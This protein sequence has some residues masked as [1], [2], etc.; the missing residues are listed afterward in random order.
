MALNELHNRCTITINENR[1]AQY[2]IHKLETT[3]NF[4]VGKCIIASP[5]L[6]ETLVKQLLLSMPITIT[7]NVLHLD[8]SVISKD[9]LFLIN[10]IASLSNLTHLSVV[11]GVNQNARKSPEHLNSWITPFS[12]GPTSSSSSSQKNDIND[13]NIVNECSSTSI[14]NYT[15]KRFFVHKNLRYLH[16]DTG[17]DAQLQLSKI[18]HAFPS[19]IELSVANLVDEPRKHFKCEHTSGLLSLQSFTLRQYSN[20]SFPEKLVHML[21]KLNVCLENLMLIFHPPTQSLT[22]ALPTTSALLRQFIE[23]Q[24]ASL[25][26]L[27]LIQVEDDVCSSINS[28][29]SKLDKNGATATKTTQEVFQQNICIPNVSVSSKGTD[30]RWSFNYAFPSI[31]LFPVTLPNLEVLHV[32]KPLITNLALVLKH[33]PRLRQLSIQVSPNGSNWKGMLPQK[34]ESHT[35][36]KEFKLDFIDLESFTRLGNFFPC[37]ET[38]KLAYCDVR[39]INVLCKQIPSFNVGAAKNKLTVCVECHE[40]QEVNGDVSY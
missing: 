13:N 7:I 22:K 11:S 9:A 40:G 28:Y 27:K 16:F 12:S 1:H 23:S 32:Q 6:D 38:L 36:V 39:L 25:K 2:V 34:L 19:L 35:E 17:K 14:Y 33:F 8:S 15:E 24:Q 3:P 30:S 5:Y 29:C 10:I 18:L 21:L 37:L 26:S 31:S 20:I 4:R